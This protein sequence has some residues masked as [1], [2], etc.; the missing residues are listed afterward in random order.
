M[1]R[2]HLLIAVLV[3]G[4]TSS[5][6]ESAKVKA[7][8]SVAVANAE[9]EAPPPPGT[10]RYRFSNQGS[11]VQ[12]VGAKITG[13]HEGSFKTFAGTILISGSA[14]LQG[15]VQ[16]TIE[17]SSVE[18]E[19]ASLAQQ[20]RSPDFFDAPRFPKATFVSTAVR[21]GGENSATH[22]VTGNLTLHGVTKAVTFPASIRVG[23]DNVEVD[24]Q[25]TINRKDFGILYPGLPDD[26]IKDD[27]LIK[28]AARAKKT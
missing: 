14:P 16:V 22:T 2:S 10:T 27:V 20:L 5:C 3:V 13:K 26:L 25:F 7:R 12:F 23:G 11:Q 21:E 9:P 24:A 6:K 17:T 8:E 4:L 28:L 15:G 18:V 1:R 19:P